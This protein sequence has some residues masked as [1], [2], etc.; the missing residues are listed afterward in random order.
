MIHIRALRK[1][2]VDA[3]GRG[4]LAL[5]GIDAQVRERECVAVVGPSGCGKATLLR[6]VNALEPFDEGQIDV[7]GVSLRHGDEP[8]PARLRA[9][10]EGVGMVFQELHLFP[11]L[12]ALENVALA[13]RVVVGQSRT[14]AEAY[15]RALLARVGLADRASSHPYQLSGGQKQRVAIARAHAMPLRVLLLDE[16]TSALDPDLREEVRAVLRSLARERSLTILL[17]THE[18]RLAT[19]L[20]DRVWVIKDGRIAA[21]GPPREV[22]TDAP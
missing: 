2:Y 18:T 5:D 4:R 8:A 3:A 10:R 6:C 19:E 22:L 15:G 20:A 7:A 9:L 21:Q 16:P 14:D 13:P 1:R 12:T 17:V 11:H